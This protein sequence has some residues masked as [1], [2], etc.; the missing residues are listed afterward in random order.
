M[1]SIVSS[2][3]AVLVTFNP[4]LNIF[5]KAIDTISSQINHLIV[6]DNFSQNRHDIINFLSDKKEVVL[7]PQDS[8]IGLAAAQN[9]GIQYIKNNIIVTHVI[10]FDQDSIIEPFFMKNLISEEL[11]LN[12]KGI[13]VGA[14][15]PSFYDPENN[16]VYPATVYVGPFIKQVRLGEKPVEATFLIASG[17]LI[18]IDVLNHI[19][20]M[21]E[22]LFI[23]YID[24]E[25]SMRARKFGYKL[26]ITSK[27]S[28]AHSIG[29][30]R[31]SLFGR[32]ISCHSSFR[33]YFLVRNSFKMLRLSYI[34][35]GYKTREIIFNFL[36]VLIGL[37]TSSDKKKFIKYTVFAIKDGISG[38]FGPCKHNF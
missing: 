24:V 32:T 29:D 33:R 37:A 4:D 10:L 14:I 8:N 16:Q 36:R 23:D 12:K 17:C 15:G 31:I 34:P 1:S 19:G 21:L 22:D 20:G 7:L 38:K 9:I 3:A 2:I 35:F 13:K 30:K 11:E 5:Q 18:N 27:A 26:F 6:V 25:W 28:M